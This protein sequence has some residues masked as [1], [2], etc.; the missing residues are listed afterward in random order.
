MPQKESRRI[1]LPKNKTLRVLNFDAGNIDPDLFCQGTVTNVMAIYP[2][3][4]VITS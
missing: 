1:S 3:R 4:L 2:E